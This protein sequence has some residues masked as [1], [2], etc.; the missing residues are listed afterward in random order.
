MKSYLAATV[1]I[2]LALASSEPSH[3]QTGARVAQIFKRLDANGDGVITLEEWLAAG[4][5]ETGFKLVDTNVD[6]KITLEELQAAI[7]KIRNR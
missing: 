7:A 4:R 2:F 6:G 3:A 1:A 5:K